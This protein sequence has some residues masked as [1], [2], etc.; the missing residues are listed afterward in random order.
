MLGDYSPWVYHV[1]IGLSN[2]VCFFK[3]QT[4]LKD[5]DSDFIS[6]KRL[7][8][9]PRS[10]FKDWGFLSSR[11]LNCDINCEH[12]FHLGQSPHC[13]EWLERQAE[14]MGIWN[15]HFLLC[16]EKNSFVSDTV[17]SCLLS[18][19][20]KLWKTNLLARKRGKI[21]DKK[22]EETRVGHRKTNYQTRW[23]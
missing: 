18:A 14:P 10:L 21:Q 16:F 22:Q 9:C 17:G 1:S 2:F 5:K 20:M 4:A 23:Y 7:G 6:E 13:P 11:L 15:S 19:S 8:R 3:L 12:N